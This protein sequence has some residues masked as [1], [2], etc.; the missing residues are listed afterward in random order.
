MSRIV[1][2]ILISGLM[3]CSA[4]TSTIHYY[5][6]SPPA[7]NV[8]PLAT[9]PK[10]TTLK[11]NKILLA[12]YLK[13]SSLSMQVA[14]NKMYFSHQD[15]WAESLESAIFEALLIE[16]NKDESRQFI[17]YITPSLNKQNAELT[18]KVD[19]FH[20]TDQSTVVVSGYFWISSLKTS[21]RLEIPY[22]I[23][24]PLYED[25]YSHAVLKQ[26]ELLQLLAQQIQQ[27][28]GKLDL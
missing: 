27:E 11:L 10:K 6:L 20:P 28:L 1:L 17:G 24:L 8:D 25:G 23:S 4:Q 22:L 12:D 15:I 7:K 5:M 21:D 14:Q 9:T 18:V 13:Q 2:L 3:A 16:L 26:R 19:H